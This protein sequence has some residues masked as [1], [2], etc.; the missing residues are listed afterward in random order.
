ML[1]RGKWELPSMAARK[2]LRGIKQSLRMPKHGTQCTSSLEPRLA[3]GVRSL[4]LKPPLQEP[5]QATILLAPKLAAVIAAGI[6]CA[7][8]HGTGSPTVLLS[9]PPSQEESRSIGEPKERRGIS[10]RN[11]RW[12]VV[13]CGEYCPPRVLI[14]A[15]SPSA[16]EQREECATRS[17]RHFSQAGQNHPPPHPPQSIHSQSHSA[18]GS[19]PR[20]PLAAQARQR[21]S[22]IA[23]SCCR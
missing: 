1:Q 11:H 18:Y 4:F 10:C 12:R 22:T 14:P 20:A 6:P 17:M 15:Q 2:A 8:I 23:S 21:Y 9:Q 3:A 7:E 16:A 19:S 13:R 5:K